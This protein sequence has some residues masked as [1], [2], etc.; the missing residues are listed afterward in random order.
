MSKEIK[1]IG[2][3][4]SG[5]DAPGMNAAIRAVVRK[6]ISN[7]VTV[8]GIKRGY[9]GLL[10]FLILFSVVVQFLV[11]LVVWNSRSRMYRLMQQTSVESTVLMAW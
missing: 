6:A 2:V 7:G 10:T 9:A 5:G 11:Q 8:K 4:T 1:C 3:L